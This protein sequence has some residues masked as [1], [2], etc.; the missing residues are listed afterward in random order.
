MTDFSAVEY[1]I[2]LTII[3]SCYIAIGLRFLVR[4]RKTGHLINYLTNSAQIFMLTLSFFVTFSPLNLY[5]AWDWKE[6]VYMGNGNI[7]YIWF[8]A[9]MLPL[10]NTIHFNTLFRRDSCNPTQVY[11]YKA[12]TFL[13]IAN[14]LLVSTY[15]C[16]TSKFQQ[17]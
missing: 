10:Q 6:Y 7:P 16:L 11:Y 14:F 17:L 3:I 15:I 1:F 13:R 4:P 5:L 9:Y 2:P 12:P 8:N